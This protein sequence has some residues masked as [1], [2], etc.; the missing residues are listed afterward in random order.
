MSSATVRML[1]APTETTCWMIIV[2]AS[3]CATVKSSLA[4]TTPFNWLIYEWEKDNYQW[5]RVCH[6]T[7]PYEISDLPYQMSQLYVVLLYILTVSTHFWE[8]CLAVELR[9]YRPIHSGR[10]GWLLDLCNSCWIIGTALL[11]RKNKKHLHVL[12]WDTGVLKETHTHVYDQTYMFL[13][14]RMRFGKLHITC[15]MITRHFLPLHI[16]CFKITHWVF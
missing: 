6:S 13:N 16:G 2:S 11:H 9:E 10:V 5:A 7:Y 8:G 3:S 12:L 15:F 1:A 14:K 4:N